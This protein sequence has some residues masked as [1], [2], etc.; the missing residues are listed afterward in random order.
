MNQ[1]IPDPYENSAI[2]LLFKV[3]K[4]QLQM[5]RDRGFNIE[6]EEPLFSYRVSDFLDQ[7][8]RIAEESGVP[9]KSALSGLYQDATGNNNIYVYYPETAKD[10]KQLGKGQ[11]TDVIKLMSGYSGLTNIII[12]S[13]LPLSGEARKAFESLPALHMEHFLYD[14]LTYNPTEHYLTPRHEVLSEEAAR[15]YLQRNKMKFTQLREFSIYDPIARY[16][17]VRPGQIVRVHR[18]N[19]GAD[20][21]AG[22]SIAHRAAVDKP[23]ENKKK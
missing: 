13:Q 16:F 19:L 15:E 20:S 2:S 10:A 21:L 11:I 5:V 1:Y 6:L 18:I 7:Y 14:D 3:K 8:T 9:F 4:T 22:K 23:L 17:G 12:I